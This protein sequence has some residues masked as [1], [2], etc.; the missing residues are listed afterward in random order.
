MAWSTR[1]A[2]TRAAS[3]SY[4]GSI[5]R[6]RPTIRK[7]FTMWIDGDRPA[8]ARYDLAIQGAV[9]VSPPTSSRFQALGPT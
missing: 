7:T 4:R 6:S 8:A 9:G 1:W 2:A 5:R 3:G